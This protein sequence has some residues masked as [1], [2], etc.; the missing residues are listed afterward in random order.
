MCAD[1]PTEDKTCDKRGSFYKTLGSTF[2]HILTS[3]NN[4]YELH[5]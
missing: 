4:E 5:C 2:D 1:V 3:G